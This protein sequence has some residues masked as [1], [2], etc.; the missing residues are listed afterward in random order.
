MSGKGDGFGCGGTSWAPASLLGV[1]TGGVPW[2]NHW[3]RRTY[4][5]I[6]ARGCAASAARGF[7]C[8][9]RN[10]TRPCFSGHN[11]EAWLK[12]G[13]PWRNHWRTFSAIDASAAAS[14][15]RGF[16]CSTVAE[17]GGDGSE[18]LLAGASAAARPVT[19][20]KMAERTACRAFRRAGLGGLWGGGAGEEGRAW[21]CQAGSVGHGPVGCGEEAGAGCM[22]ASMERPRGR[23]RDRHAWGGGGPGGGRHSLRAQEEE[24]KSGGVGA[25]QGGDL[26]AC[27]GGAVAASMHETVRH[28]TVMRMCTTS[29]QRALAAH[30]AD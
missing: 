2:R 11:K 4:A 8:T 30:I 7:D 13:V 28:A 24:A 25:P 5:A 19:A 21:W 22:R 3:R 29:P 17:P 12:P 1:P 9:N 18:G 20:R 26:C 6:D 23:V 27:G 14:A 15:A 16:D 10:P